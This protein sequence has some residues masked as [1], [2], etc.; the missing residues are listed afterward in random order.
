MDMIKISCKR[1]DIEP[2]YAESKVIISLYDVD[3][4]DI[5]TEIE[6]SEICAE[7]FDEGKEEARDELD[8]EEVLEIFEACDLLA[9]IDNDEIEKYYLEF[10]KLDDD[11]PDDEPPK[12]FPKPRIIK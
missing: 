12:T 7:K 1:A 6:E 11:S 10:I 5:E 2:N 9:D 4:S 3:E 8:I